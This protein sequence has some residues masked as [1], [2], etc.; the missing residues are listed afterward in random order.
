VPASAA[1][2]AAPAATE[3]RPEISFRRRVRLLAAV[4]ELWHFRE[5]VL[6]IAER[7]L[8]VRYK[9]AVLGIAWALITP[10]IMMI[11]FTVIFTKVAQVITHTHGVPYP[12]FSYLGLLPW[13]FF[14]TFIA[15]RGD[16]PVGNVPLLNKLYCPREMFPIAA[17]IDAAVD[18][19]IAALVLLLLFPLSGFAPKLT[20][21]YAPLLM[22]PLIAFT[23][24][25][26]LAISVIVVY[27][28][29]LR[30]VLPLIVQMGLFAT[31]VIY[32]PETLF[33]SK[34]L[35]VAYS[36]VNPLVPVLDGQGEAP[37]WLS[38]GA[39]GAGRA[40]AGR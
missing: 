16:E 11:A 13:T 19:L 6:T 10:V 23:L 22:I 29:D 33:K 2:L 38:Y 4:R 18:G 8:R 32:S 28:R 39:A 30:L 37:N 14:S 3:P 17:M 34:L 9:Q 26:L 15:T 35:L 40:T 31:P 7:D 5:L 24:G 25:L 1:V 21:L 12:L 36:V 20:S 27:M